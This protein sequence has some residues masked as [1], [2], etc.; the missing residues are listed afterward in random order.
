MGHDLF[1]DY[2]RNLGGGSLQS[3]FMVKNLSI[4]LDSL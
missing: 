3:M 1:N 2:L 4:N